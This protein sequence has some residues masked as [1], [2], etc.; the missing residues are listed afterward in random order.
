MKPLAASAIGFVLI[1]QPALAGGTKEQFVNAFKS[2]CGT[3]A[4]S[5]DVV[6]RKAENRKLTIASDMNP[7]MAGGNMIETKVWANDDRTGSY[8]VSAS[9]AINGRKHV[10]G[11]GIYFQDIGDDLTDY[12]SVSLGIGKPYKRTVASD[13]KHLSYWNGPTHTMLMLT[14]GPTGIPQGATLNAIQTL[15]AGR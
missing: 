7:P 1:A 12:V 13:G 8:A 14:S 10:Q 9:R 4:P 5:F 3:G 2:W 15:D 11:C 6:N